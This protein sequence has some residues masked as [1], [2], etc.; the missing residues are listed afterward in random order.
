VKPPTGT[1]D[2]VAVGRIRRAHGTAGVVVV[3]P[4]TASAEE[5][6]S[7]GRTLIAG[8]VKGEAAV[9]E[10][11]LHIEMSEPFQGGFR[12]QFRE[13]ADRDEADRWRN[14]HLLS[15]RS[16]LPEPD[17]S[18]I[19]LHDLV[20]LTVE[21]PDRTPIGVVEAYYELPH[22]VMIEVKRESDLVM[23]PYRFVSEVD[24]EGK[25]LVVEPPEGLL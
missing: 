7:V 14:R 4:M 17:E 8:T 11:A 5:V 3:E 15:P 12:V 25:R 21:G 6:F 24:L 10:K 22:D 13:I 16:E 20:G 1:S 18:E 19:Y 23:V 9:P 2:L